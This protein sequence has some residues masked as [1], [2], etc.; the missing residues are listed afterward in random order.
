MLAAMGNLDTEAPAAASTHKPSKPTSLGA[1]AKPKK[2]AAPK[3][4]REPKPKAEPAVAT[5]RQPSRRHAAVT[6]KET[7][8]ERAERIK[9]RI[10]VRSLAFVH[11]SC[12]LHRAD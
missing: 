11:L 8:E 2:S 12:S 3:P 10:R 1:P 5:R 7:E 4:K 6:L 9:V